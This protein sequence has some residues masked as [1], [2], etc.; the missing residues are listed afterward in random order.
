MIGALVTVKRDSGAAS[1]SS[2][3]NE[4]YLCVE[5]LWFC[6]G[7]PEAMSDFVNHAILSHHSILCFTRE[8]LSELVCRFIFDAYVLSAK[9]F[10]VHE[11][12]HVIVLHVDVLRST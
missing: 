12:L 3:K 6:R 1:V 5:L 11:L 8:R 7:R 4:D 9:N 2:S 10:A